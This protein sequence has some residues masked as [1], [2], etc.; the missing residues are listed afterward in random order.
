MNSLIF[1]A[2]AAPAPEA[3]PASSWI[4]IIMLV[5]FIG[6]M[7]F[8]MIR[9]QKKQ[10]KAEAKM[11]SELQI[12]DKFITIGGIYGRVVSLKDDSIVIESSGD[13]SKLQVTRTAVAQN[14]TIHD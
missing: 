9:P 2:D 10:Q 3:N 6:I 7:Y 5:V 13:R 8:F 1:L 11:R 4:S 14:L 12:G